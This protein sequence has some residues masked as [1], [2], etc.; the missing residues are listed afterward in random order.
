MAGSWKNQR[1]QD[2]F[3]VLCN[4]LDVDRIT[5]VLRA[6]HMLTA[7]EFEQLTNPHFTTQTRRQKLLL[8]IPRKGRAHFEKLGECLVWSGQS[9]LARKI[10]VPV[11]DIR[12]SP[13]PPV[14]Q[15]S[16]SLQAAEF[17][18]MMHMLSATLSII[19]PL[20]VTQSLL[21]SLLPPPAVAQSLLPPLPVTITHLL[22]HD[23]LHSALLM[24]QSGLSQL[25]YSHP[26]QATES[27][28]SSSYHPRPSGGAV[29]P[30]PPDGSDPEPSSPKKVL[31]LYCND[32]AMG[33]GGDFSDSVCALADFLTRVCGQR[34]RVH[35]DLYITH[36]P[37]NW[38]RWTER[39][40]RESDAVLLV[41]SKTLKHML[42]HRNPDRPVPMKKGH[43]DAETVYNLIR[44]PKFIPVFVKP[45]G[46]G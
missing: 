31:V 12:P 23:T 21:E 37:S 26:V 46:A 14:Q 34:T 35:C 43:F 41:C 36:P 10:G 9:E 27:G 7:D 6:E 5:P 13:H 44:S 38:T 17:A 45:H 30:P 20:L 8:F 16:T 39:E 29:Y 18:R 25:R 3:V 19:P 22:L 40:I 11:E 28:G 2:H 32:E 1:I 24:L 33:G 42:D 4:E 15:S